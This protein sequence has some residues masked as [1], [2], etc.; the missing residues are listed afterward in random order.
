MIASHHGQYEF[1][2]AE[3]ADDA[4]GRGPPPPR[5]PRRQ[6]GR[7]RSSSSRTRP[8]IEDGWTQYQQSH[9]RKFFRRPRDEAAS[10]DAAAAKAGEEPPRQ[11]TRAWSACSGGRPAATDSC[12]RSTRRRETARPTSTSPPHAALDAASGD[13]VRVRLAEA[14]DARRPGPAGEIVEVVERRTTRFVG[15]YFEAAGARLGAGRR[16]GFRQAGGGGRSRRQGRAATTTRSSS[17][18]CGFP[19]H[20]RD[21][22][23]VIVEVLGKAGDAG[24]RH[25]DG[26]PRV[27]PARPLPRGGA[28]PMPGGRP[29]GSTRRCRPAAATSPTASIITIDPVDARDFDD[30]ISL[31]RIERGPLAARR[32][33]RRR[34]ALRPRGLAAR[35]GGAGSRGTSVYLPDRVIPMIPEVVSNNLA[36][37]QPGQVRYARTCWIEFTADGVPVHAGWSGRRSA[38]RG[39]SPTRRSTC[40]SP[41]PARRPSR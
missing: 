24:R 2:V 31:E 28:R 32:A 23:G 40:S 33:H 7:R 29:T 5:P 18:W 21:G 37:L 27:R 20:L 13:T 1:G 39:G 4:R 30:A 6:D 25:A 15:T 34:L 11:A 14:R 16:H 12:G 10:H 26:D 8:S 36:S 19:T 17:R 3:A 38:A 41:T 22:E 35:P 9:G